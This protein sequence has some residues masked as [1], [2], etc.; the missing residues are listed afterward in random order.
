[1]LSLHGRQGSSLAHSA[2]WI[3]ALGYEEECGLDG[4]GNSVL[5]AVCFKDSTFVLFSL[6]KHPELLFTI[7]PR[8]AINPSTTSKLNAV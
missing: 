7:S 4:E 6:P 1:M 3:T 5:A 2:P 8:Q